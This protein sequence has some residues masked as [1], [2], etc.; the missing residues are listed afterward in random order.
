MS[1]AQQIEVARLFTTEGTDPMDQVEWVRTDVTIWNRDG[2]VQFEMK[3]VEAPKHWSE[4]AVTI[5]ASKYLKRATA[6]N[7]GRG[8]MSIKALILRVVD[9]ISEEARKQGYFKTPESA[10]IFR[11]ELAH[12]MVNQKA[13]FNS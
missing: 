7:E 4:Q 1:D 3:G 5:A 2:S 13:S 6:I 12:I 11:D 8:E 9:T 10:K